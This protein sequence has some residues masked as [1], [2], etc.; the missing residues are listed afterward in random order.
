MI[1]VER[2]EPE[3]IRV[4]PIAPWSFALRGSRAGARDLRAELG[5]AASDPVVGTVSVLR[6]QKALDVLVRA[7]ALLF[8]DFPR[9]KVLIAGAGPEEPALR[10]LISELGLVDTVI[11]LGTWPGEEVPDLLSAID[12]A[13]NCS[14]F[15]GTSAAIAEFMAAARPVVATRVGGTPDLIEHGVHGLLVEPQDVAGLAQAISRLLVNRELRARLGAAG[16]ARQRREYD[17]PVLV[18]RLEDLYESLWLSSERGRSE[19]SRT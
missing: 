17:V 3:R 5:I 2:I 16:Q 19:R 6:A 10:A 8:P 11:L 15:E 7:A 18:R 1:E 9:L 12:V 4:T 13:V 14:N